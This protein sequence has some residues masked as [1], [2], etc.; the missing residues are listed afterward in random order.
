MIH[1]ASLRK[2]MSDSNRPMYVFRRN[3]P[4]VTRGKCFFA[5]KEDRKSSDKRR[6][7]YVA[8]SL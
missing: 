6:A 1:P 4:T 2:R 7:V 8:R 5:V 3:G